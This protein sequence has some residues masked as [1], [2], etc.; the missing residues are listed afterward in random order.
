M[1]IPTSR[2]GGSI[3]GGTAA[4]IFLMVAALP[5]SA[6]G[7]STPKQ[8][9]GP[10]SYWIGSVGSEN[11]SVV[12]SWLENSG[13]LV[14]RVSADKG[15]TFAP[16][17]SVGSANPGAVT[18]CGGMVA[19]VR[20]NTGAGTVKLDLRS[21][22]GAFSESRTLASARNLTLTGN[23]VTCV[24][25]RRLATFWDEWVSGVLRLKVAVVPV[26]EPLESYEFDLGSAHLYRVRGITATE[27]GIWM[28]WSRGD[29]IL[30]QRLDVGSGP[31]MNVSK[32]P[33]AHIARMT[34]APGVGVAAVGDRVYVGYG[35]NN[36]AFIRASNDGGRT[37]GRARMLYDSTPT[38]PVD[39]FGLT[40]R[41]NV[42]AASVHL[43]PWCGGC[44]GSN[45]A[46]YS[47]NWG[48]TWTSGPD[49]V[50]GYMPNVALVG[51]GPS[52]RIAQAWD[53]RTSHETYG[54][55]GYIKFQFGTP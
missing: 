7:W 54:D 30:V 13:T 3:L 47:T 32:G 46:V 10:G 51:S 27:T 25:G 26:A 18:I 23:G 48:R 40:A 11:N 28:A 55:P 5:V 39:F 19:A 17:V 16:P 45:R 35:R 4:L 9:A 1:R 34:G 52:M 2:R 31:A 41:E 8:L 12:V 15:R 37:F 33:R 6:A 49:N 38:D 29:G 24:G 21:M 53:N 42:V 36:D 22:D 43:G 50:G 20:V 44:V 14:Y